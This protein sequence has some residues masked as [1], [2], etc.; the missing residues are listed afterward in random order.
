MTL[1]FFSSITAY[2]QTMKNAVLVIMLVLTSLPSWSQS[3]YKTDGQ[4]VLDPSG[5]EIH[6]VGTNLGHWLVPE[7]YIF[8]FK[9]TSSPTWI[10]VAFQQLIGKYGAAEFW[11]DFIA[12]YVTEADIEHLRAIG[13]NHVR[14]PFNYKM[15]T[16]E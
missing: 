11:D 10:D 7:G 12:N 8:K 14:L 6:L 16:N 9:R 13:C 4:K 5:K 1:T 3:F 15:L 2:F